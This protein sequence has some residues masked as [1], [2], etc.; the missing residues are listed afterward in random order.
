MAEQ[1]PRRLAQAS[2]QLV[3]SQLVHSQLVHSR[4]RTRDTAD[5]TARQLT[6][7]AD[8]AEAAHGS[9]GRAGSCVR[10]GHSLRHT[11]WPQRRGRRC[12]HREL[13]ATPTP[14]EKQRQQQRQQKQHEQSPENTRVRCKLESAG[15][16]PRAH[17]RPLLRNGA[18]PPEQV[19][20]KRGHGR[21]AGRG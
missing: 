8:D 11:M 4:A 18:L 20:G 3:H 10:E 16:L 7:I 9:L 12:H 21:V 15:A 17:P 6:Q 2:L 14:A 19:N 1:H 5:G 13:T